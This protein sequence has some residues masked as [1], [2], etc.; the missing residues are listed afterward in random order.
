[1]PDW[2]A[3]ATAAARQHA[4]GAG[5]LAGIG[6]SWADLRRFH[7]CLQWATSVFESCVAKERMLAAELGAI[8]R[9]GAA[10]AQDAALAALVADGA[11]REH[12]AGLA[13]DMV[14]RAPVEMG[15]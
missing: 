3:L 10:S 5:P 8:E 2:L 11:R 15:V 4:A 9:G 12:S 13:G 6:L 14:A 7:V 1:M